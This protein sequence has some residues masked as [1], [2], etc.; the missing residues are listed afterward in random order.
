KEAKAEGTLAVPT[1]EV[2]LP[3]VDFIWPLV[4]SLYID[5]PKPTDDRKPKKV[6]LNEANFARK[7]FQSLWG[8]ISHKA[9][10]QVEFD[11]DELIRKAV[12]HMDKHLNVASMQYVIQ[13]GK[14]RDE[15]EADDLSKGSGFAVSTT[16][17]VTETVTAGSQVK[18]DLLGEI[19]EKT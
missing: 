10:Y 17:T 19:A 14:Q 11:S 16:E 4:D 15:L 6:P 8:R 18:Y 9:V 7:E 2:L 12:G 3:V 1:S 13:S 5:V